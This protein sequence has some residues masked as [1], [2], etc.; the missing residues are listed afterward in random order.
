MCDNPGR[1]IKCFEHQ[2]A[3]D[4]LDLRA[5]VTSWNGMSFAYYRLGDYDK[6]RVLAERSVELVADAHSLPALIAHEVRTRRL[7]DAR[8]HAIQ[9][10]N[11]WPDFRAS[12]SRDLFLLTRPTS[13]RT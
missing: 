13:I 5:R 11:I 2:L 8:R 9:L 3:V 7:A 4:P 6:G 12:R 1:A 10:M